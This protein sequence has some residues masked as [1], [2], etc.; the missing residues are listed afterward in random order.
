MSDTSKFWLSVWVVV[1]LTLSFITFTISDFYK[2]QDAAV[3]E[4]VKQGA[5]PIEAMCSMQ[6]TLGRHPICVVEALKQ[7]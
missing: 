7:Q 1:G 5:S 6:D 4:M 3:V 2:T